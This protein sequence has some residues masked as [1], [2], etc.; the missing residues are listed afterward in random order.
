MEILITY[1][2]STEKP[3]GRRRLRRVSKACEAYC[4]RVQKS[5]FE[6]VLNS[7]Q[8]AQLEYRLH[9]EIDTGEDS[10]RIY[11]LSEPRHKHLRIIGKEPEFDLREPLIL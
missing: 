11:K 1:D 5:V 7:A 6:C 10:L 8:L 9:R 3:E 2:V 4:Q